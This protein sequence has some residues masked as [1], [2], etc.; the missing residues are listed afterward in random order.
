MLNYHQFQQL[1]L[2]RYLRKSHNTQF[3]AGRQHL[4]EDKGLSPTD[5]HSFDK[6]LLGNEIHEKE[7]SEMGLAEENQ[8]N[9][10]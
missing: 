8:K 3:T 6:E 5:S 9:N 7:P 2:D 4:D 10:P 1:I